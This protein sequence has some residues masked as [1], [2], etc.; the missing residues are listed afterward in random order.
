MTK[1]ITVLGGDKRMKYAHEYFLKKGIR[2]EIF[3]NGDSIIP[4][5]TEKTVVLPL[6]VMREGF[7]FAPDSELNITHE[8]LFGVIRGCENLF[9]GMADSKIKSF[10]LSQGIR[11]FDYFENETLLNENAMLTAGALL[12]LLKN[13]K[14][15]VLDGEV[16]ILGFGRTGSR[17]ARLIS[18]DGGNVT[19]VTGKRHIEG[20]K[21]ISFDELEEHIGSASLIINTVA[22][23]VLNSKLLKLMKKGSA[24]VEIA[25]Y[26]YGIDFTAAKKE[27]IRVIRAPS[28][29]GRFFPLESGEAVARTVLELLGDD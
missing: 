17:I 27:K 13:E 20:Y 2:S 10:A 6:P 29:P 28:L 19:A 25:S 5:T 23:P 1:S 12:L 3:L 22:S 8:K 11:F 9:C 4:K 21:Y 7:L 18:E 24:A 16:F 15:D 14:V 26:P